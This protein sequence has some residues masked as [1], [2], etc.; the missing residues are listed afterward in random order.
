MNLADLKTEITTDPAGLG[1]AGKS[2]DQI[3]KIM[4]SDNGTGSNFEINRK[5]ISG[6]DIVSCIVGSEYLALSAA[7]RD[8]T[9]FVTGAGTLKVKTVKDDLLAVYT[10]AAAPISRAALQDAFKQ[11]VS[12]AIKVVGE[13]VTPSD[14]A[15]AKRI[16]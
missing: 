1:Y 2:D 9:A 11:T 10:Q 16:V 8:Y 7:Q 5:E 4:M 12:R 13:P 14:V 15:N 3:A 6:S